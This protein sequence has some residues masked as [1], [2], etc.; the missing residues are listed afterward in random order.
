MVL[1]GTQHADLGHE[2][3]NLGGLRLGG[4][5]SFV[6]GTSVDSQD[7]ALVRRCFSSWY[8]PIDGARILC[9]LRSVHV[10]PTSAMGTARRKDSECLSDRGQFG[11][12]DSDEIDVIQLNRNGMISGVEIDR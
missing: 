5:I 7:R 12:L 4:W 6:G 8:R 9:S 11:F 2:S 10:S 1:R 3:S